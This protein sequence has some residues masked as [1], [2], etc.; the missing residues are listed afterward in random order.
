M[1]IRTAS[2]ALLAIIMLS[3]ALLS[4]AQDAGI[5]APKQRPQSTT[6]LA[7]AGTTSED[8]KSKAEIRA[9][10]TPPISNENSEWK[11]TPALIA[12]SLSAFG[13]FFASGVALY[14]GYF[15]ARWNRPRLQLA[16]KTDD[17]FYHQ[18]SVG[19]YPLFLIFQCSPIEIHK[20]FF[21]SRIKVFNTGK[22]TAKNVLARIEYIEFLSTQDRK[23]YPIYYHPSIVKWSGERDWNSIDIVA[24]SHHFL[25]MFWSVNETD[26][27]ILRFNMDNYKLQGLAIKEKTLLEIIRKDVVPERL[28]Y[29]G[30]W[31]DSSYS[32]GIRSRYTY[33]GLMNVYFTINSD[34]C[35]PLAFYASI[36]WTRETWNKPSISV[37][38]LKY[39]NGKVYH[40]KL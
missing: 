26:E 35:D 4:Y 28:T 22:T 9:G 38:K 23:P 25:D 21:N 8:S 39:H 6:Q 40:E 37:I 29:W 17:P 19:A 18:L 34:N 2:L 5:S 14:L 31:I 13:S 7:Q 3:C 36:T 12:Q 27:A 11:L 24:G 32:R 1:R 16:F 15:R 30:V 10:D 20:P 33:E